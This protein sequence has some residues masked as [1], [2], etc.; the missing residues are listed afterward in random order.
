MKDLSPEHLVKD[1]KGKLLDKEEP[2]K[3]KNHVTFL[4]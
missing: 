1:N 3:D 4:C 2:P